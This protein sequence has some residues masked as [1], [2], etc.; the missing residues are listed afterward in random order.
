M[1][2]KHSV[3]RQAAFVVVAV[4]IGS[5]AVGFSRGGQQNPLEK[6]GK[7][8]IHLNSDSVNSGNATID[9]AGLE[10][11]ALEQLKKRSLSSE[12]WK[13]LFVVYT[14]P[15][16][17]TAVLPLLGRYLVESA[18]IRFVPRFPLLQGM[19][20][21]ARF[22]VGLFRADYGDKKVGV[23][24][25]EPS[26]WIVGQIEVAK[27]VKVA[28]TYVEQIYPTSSEIPVNQLKFYIHFSGPMSFGEAYQHISLH[29]HAGAEVADAFLVLEQELWDPDRMRLTLLLDPGRIKSGLRP[30]LE[31]GL[32][33]TEG[34]SYSLVIDPHWRDATGI[35]LKEEFRKDFRVGEGDRTPPNHKDWRLIAPDAATVEPVQLVF[36]ESLD[37]ALL[38]RLLQVRNELDLEVLGTIETTDQ[39]RQWRFTP[40]RPW[41]AGTYSIRVNTILEDLAGNNL[42]KPFDLDLQQNMIVSYQDYVTLRFE[43]R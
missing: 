40:H 30:N 27:D 4:A 18:R 8:R 9:I 38:E 23:S 35:P 43:V 36:P 14:A 21:S 25:Q 11:A 32:A 26:E 7:I 20:Y 42:R 37:H 16:T 22:N 33:L 15:T 29:D 24:S 19:T 39:E 2:G 6:R 12:Q 31:Q 34:E 17:G 3:L 5:T 41:L 13:N 1:A 10:L 28:R